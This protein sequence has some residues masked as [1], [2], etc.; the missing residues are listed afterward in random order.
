M[1]FTT[2]MAK[3]TLPDPKQK[4]KQELCEMNYHNKKEMQKD[5]KSLRVNKP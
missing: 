1:A 5:H 4:K 3:N 2:N